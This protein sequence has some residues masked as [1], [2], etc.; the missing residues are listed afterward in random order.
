MVD[1]NGLAVG[2]VFLYKALVGRK[3]AVGLNADDSLSIAVPM[4]PLPA[5][6]AVGTVN[7]FRI[8]QINGNN[9]V[10]ALTEDSVTTTAT[11]SNAKTVTRL[12]ASNN[13]V[14]MLTYD[15]P[16]DGLLYRAGNSCTINNAQASPGISAYRP[17]RS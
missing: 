11:D 8:F 4:N 6:P 17:D 7:N 5:L 10:S 1:E 14:D 9:S 13:R 15:K 3:V 12:L 2:R 16:R